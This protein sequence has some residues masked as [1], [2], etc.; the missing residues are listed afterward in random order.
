MEELLKVVKE[1]KPDYSS[2]YLEVW[3]V[4]EDKRVYRQFIRGA[5]GGRVPL[6]TRVQV[7]EKEGWKTVFERR[8]M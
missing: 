8:E 5:K 2:D 3:R 4:G 6:W 7:R 1:R